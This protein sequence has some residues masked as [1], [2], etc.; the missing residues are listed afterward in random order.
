MTVFSNE[1]LVEAI[2][3]MDAGHPVAIIKMCRDTVL[4]GRD[5]T[6]SSKDFEAY[7]NFA[8]AVMSINMKVGNSKTSSKMNLLAICDMKE[9]VKASDMPEKSRDIYFQS[10]PILQSI[11]SPP[12]TEFAQRMLSGLNA[13]LESN[14]GFYTGKFT[15]P[16]A[17]GDVSLIGMSDEKR[18]KL[19]SIGLS[20]RTFNDKKIAWAGD[21]AYLNYA[22]FLMTTINGK[23]VLERLAIGGEEDFIAYSLTRILGDLDIEKKC[24]DVLAQEGIG[25]TIS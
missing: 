8:I 7:L 17:K 14:F 3:L 23:S 10:L 22:N 20:S 2:R 11:Q 1:N 15:N 9:D 24:R 16:M 19:K 5:L 21:A 25:D 13:A 18:G 4:Q 6:M 12:E